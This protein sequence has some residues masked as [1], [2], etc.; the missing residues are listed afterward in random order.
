MV[1]DLIAIARAVDSRLVLLLEKL[2]C[3]L[4][5]AKLLYKAAFYQIRRDV[6]S[7]S[8][9]ST[10]HQVIPRAKDKTRTR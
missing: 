5:G 10:M 8:L 9:S 4:N 7:F 1:T 6:R 2:V 3:L